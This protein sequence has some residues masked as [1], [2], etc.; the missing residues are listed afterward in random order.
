MKMLF[1]PGSLPFQVNRFSGKIQTRDSGVTGSPSVT[2]KEGKGREG[3]NQIESYR[4][5]YSENG[6]IITPIARPLK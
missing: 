5:A 1:G 3:Q 2:K 6:K 4:E